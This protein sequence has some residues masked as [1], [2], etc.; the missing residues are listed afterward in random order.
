MTH[1]P[2]TPAAQPGTLRRGGRRP[3]AGPPGTVWPHHPGGTADTLAEII[4]RYARPGH[5]VLLL[6]PPTDAA[7]PRTGPG[8]EP[9]WAWH[10]AHPGPGLAR[11]HHVQVRTG[12]PP[13]PVS[14][15]G[16][17]PRTGLATA[18]T[19]PSARSRSGLPAGTRVAGPDPASAPPGPPPDRPQPD[20]PGP[21]SPSPVRAGL[22]VTAAG[23]H[24][25]GWVPGLPWSGLLTPSGT[26][27][28]LTR[29]HRSAG[30]W[31][32]PLPALT[33][34][35]ATAGLAWTDHITLPDP[36]LE[37]GPRTLGP[38]GS[39]PAAYAHP[40]PARVDPQPP[41]RHHP[42]HTDLLLFRP[43]RQPR[44]PSQPRRTRPTQTRSG[45][46]G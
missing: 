44:Q 25:C 38:A 5:R 9:D 41:V 46:N 32:D 19:G 40:G 24:G 15:T 29:C 18:R 16:P 22:V 4:G 11:H 13:G 31:V 10:L 7:R 36:G 20:H 21:G 1:Q 42:A 14:P 27:A 26:L 34:A 45:A 6:P 12:P 3:P 39:Q 28:V 23:P 8:R 35:L 30:R 43:V 2:R 33:A 37:P 17:A